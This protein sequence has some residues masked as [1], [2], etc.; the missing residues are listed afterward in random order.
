[1][2]SIHQILALSGLP[3]TLGVVPGTARYG[4]KIFKRKLKKRKKMQIVKEKLNSR[5][6]FKLQHII[7]I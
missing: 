5:E 4:L 1:M 2:W 7:E 6:P 3:E